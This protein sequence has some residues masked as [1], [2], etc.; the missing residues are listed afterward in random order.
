MSTLNKD[1]SITDMKTITKRDGSTASYSPALMHQAI[2]SLTQPLTNHRQY[3]SAAIHSALVSTTVR[4]KRQSGKSYSMGFGYGG[5]TRSKYSV[6]NSF[7]F[8]LIINKEDETK[9]SDYF[10]SDHFD[11]RMDAEKYILKETTRYYKRRLKA[12]TKV[13]SNFYKRKDLRAGLNGD[14][15]S[16]KNFR[17]LLTQTE[18]K[19]IRIEED[20]P[21]WM[22]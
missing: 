18:Q 1:G 20:H 8:E 16:L 22:I 11:R 2:M 6:K 9:F 10:E 14:N 3:T 7:P 12:S 4:Q 17:V 5:I 19:L 13:S 21:E 15:Q